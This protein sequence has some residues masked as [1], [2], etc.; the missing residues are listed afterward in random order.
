MILTCQVDGQMASNILHNCSYH[1][2][3]AR[4]FVVQFFVQI[5]KPS[6]SV[7]SNELITEIL[8]NCNSQQY[9]LDVSF[10]ILQK[11]YK[12][13]RKKKNII[14][15]SSDLLIKGSKVIEQQIQN[16]LDETQQQKLLLQTNDQYKLSSDKKFTELIVHETIE[17]IEFILG[18]ISNKGSYLSLWGLSLADSELADMFYCLILQSSMID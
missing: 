5:E 10:E 4:R 15:K 13:Y 11:G 16:I 9:S 17:T 14:R 18:V 7:N 3:L 6:I 8:I 2:G 12:I 1:F